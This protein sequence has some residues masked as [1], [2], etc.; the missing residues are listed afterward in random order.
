MRALVT[1]SNGF[2][3]PWLLAHL[4]E[5]GDDVLG[6]TET[7]DITDPAALQDVLASAPFDAV[8]HLA[9][10]SSVRL[11][12][13]DPVGTFTVNA[14]GTLNLCSAAIKTARPPRVL[15]ISSAEVYG[16]VRASAMPIGEDQPLA[17]VTP[18]A[19]SKASAEMIGLQAWLGRGLEVVR[20]R[21]FN[22]TGPGQ[23]PGFVVPD[24]AVQVV[25]AAQGKLERIAT[26]NLEVSRDMTDVPRRRSRLPPADGAR[27]ARG[28][29]QRVQRRGTPG[30]GRAPAPDGDCRDG[31]ARVAGPGPG[32]A[33][34][35]CRGGGGPPPHQSSHGLATRRIPLER[36][37]ADVLATYE[38]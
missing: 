17:P 6:L 14:L 20:T 7:T 8:Y 24:L 30:L 11:S 2:V 19:A 36:T 10:Q 13:D 31:R 5:S 18:Y 27:R 33:R 28:C 25:R 3:G 9:A 15:I 1:G 26:G 4:H 16:K 22:H 12:W 32:P 29:L 23:G 34:R 37:L 21:A 38:Q 35:C